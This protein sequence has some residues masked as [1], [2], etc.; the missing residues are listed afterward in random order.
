MAEP[1]SSK[2]ATGVVLYLDNESSALI[3]IP[4]FCHRWD[5]PRCSKR[6][7]S[8]ARA[9]AAAGKPE[10]MLT[11]TTRPRK[12][13][14]TPAACRWLRGRWT[15]LLRRLRRNFPRLEY[16][17]FLELHKSGWPHLHILT[18]GCYIPQR[19]LSAWWLELTGSFKVYIQK[20]HRTWQGIEE[21]TKYYL[22]TARQV[23]AAAPELPVYTKSK[24]W[25]PEDWEE[26]DRP[27][28]DYSFYCFSR[29]PWSG[30]RAVLD[31]LGVDLTPLR[32]ASDT[33][34]LTRDGPPPEDA[35]NEIYDLGSWGEMSLVSALELYF[36]NP[37][38]GPVALN[39][40]QDRHDL[41]CDPA[42]A[43]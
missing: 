13:L 23:H 2:C 12:G 8:K 30:F 28:G 11:L 5:C 9:Q 35:A 39:H 37:P 14:S 22:K 32:D 15:A 18:R 20:V 43:A 16:M 7:L 41:A 29:L 27:R 34:V 6:R 33:Y 42:Y 1:G 36:A 38:H 10:R 21:A 3:A 26:G 19:M 4:T 25:L 17:A 24:R 40:L 31:H